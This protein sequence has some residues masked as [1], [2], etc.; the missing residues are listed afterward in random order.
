V[1]LLAIL[2]YL[3]DSFPTTLKLFKRRFDINKMMRPLSSN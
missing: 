3:N 2:S 1:R